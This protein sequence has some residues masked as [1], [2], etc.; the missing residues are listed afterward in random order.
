MDAAHAAHR[1]HRIP[2]PLAERLAPVREQAARAAVLVDFDGT[3]SPIV[4]DPAAARPL[5]GAGEALA[6]LARRYARVA[7]GSGRPGSFLLTH[8]GEDA[9][10]S[11]VVLPG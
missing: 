5:P 7:V 6:E 11:G 1:A 9:V 2:E 4:E 10:G 8:L 3:L